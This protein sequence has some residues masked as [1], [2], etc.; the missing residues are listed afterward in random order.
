MKHEKRRKILKILAVIFVMFIIF[1]CF[2]NIFGAINEKYKGSQ[3][4]TG[5]ELNIGGNES[6]NI[7][8]KPIFWLVNTV[9]S[10][11]EYLLTTFARVLASADSSDSN[12]ALMPWADAIVY[13]GVPALDV[14]FIN[15]DKASFSNIMS[16]VIAKI[17]YTIFS[18]SITFFGIAVLIMAVKL[19]TTAIAAEKARYKESITNFVISLFL[20]FSMHY[21]MSFCFYLNESIVKVAFSIADVQLK[22]E[23]TKL[24][25]NAT[26]RQKNMVDKISDGSG[27]NW[28]NN[29]DSSDKFKKLEKYID[30]KLFDEGDYQKAAAY[31][32][33]GYEDFLTDTKGDL[34]NESDEIARSVVLTCMADLVVKGTTFDS[35]TMSGYSGNWKDEDHPENGDALYFALKGSYDSL[36][37]N[38]ED[39]DITRKFE[40]VYQDCFDILDDKSYSTKELRIMNAINDAV[41]NFNSS[42]GTD[43]SK[44]TEMTDLG[45]SVVSQLS[46]YFKI[47]RYT[48][49]GDISLV[50][51]IVYTIFVF[52][53]IMYFFAYLKRF[54]YIIV[55]AFFSPFLVLFDFLAKAV[56][57]QSDTLSK[58]IKEFCA[59]VFVQSIQ[60]FLL[61]MIAAL[62]VNINNGIASSED[63]NLG[64]S[65]A[66][67]IAVINIIAL[68]S[69]AKLED[70][71]SDMLGL[72]SS[73][74]D[75]SLKGGAKTGL[76]GFA[77]G[78]MTMGALR[79]LG[80]NGKKLFSGARNVASARK[81]YNNALKA[82]KKKLDQ[83]G[84]L[85]RAQNSALNE[86][87]SGGNG[88]SGS[89]SGSGS[90]AAAT[91]LSNL[92]DLHKYQD[93]MDA[94]DEKIN[95][96]KKKKRD[97]KRQ[98][99]SGVAE[100]GGALIGAG[101]GAAAAGT[102][103]AAGGD[104]Q[105]SDVMSD[106]I[107]A[108]GLGDAI[109]EEM[110]NAANGL[111]F[112][113]AGAISDTIKGGTLISRKA[114][115]HQIKTKRA[116]IENG[117][118]TP[119]DVSN[120]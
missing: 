119:Q 87:S 99:V 58:W 116:E 84:D 62:I 83:F 81:G 68:A 105:L 109:G 48:A 16:G 8:A 50:G 52:Q 30:K 86:A 72:K 13:N 113:A 42:G 54:F 17:Y 82:K 51:V 9:G 89:G 75:T 88:G 85:Q 69:M 45:N 102:Y 11:G 33:N 47:N 106:A 56:G 36:F 77:G 120:I 114:L 90:G 93:A 10:L 59:L 19:A 57:K 70:L 25:A 96:A 34:L 28:F 14:N 91:R 95:E 101:L 100:T 63:K 6:N 117:Y 92:K 18:I 103:H 76:H 110:V 43:L 66:Q 61:T 111:T 23:F 41:G 21:F 79:R 46:V 64:P 49:E 39:L 94:C 112:E 12:T 32:A 7:I 78:M 31:L 55:L 4:S 73:I 24:T 97:A 3:A 74:T 53:S 98:F 38:N 40:P 37:L 5:G 108:A 29:R 71:I 60:A 107:K 22:G 44:T 35:N 104:F 67:G 1:P 26:E 118:R 65:N 20:I 15:P 2:T 115:K 27:D 80:D